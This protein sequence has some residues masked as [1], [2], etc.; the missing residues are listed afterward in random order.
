MTKSMKIT[1]PVCKKKTVWEDN[2][3]RP[4]CSER[5]RLIDL[6]KWAS[7][8]YRIAGEKKDIP[9]ADGDEKKEDER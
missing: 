9:D 4:F 6:G 5:C 1:C 8:E 7:E 3:F 2:Q